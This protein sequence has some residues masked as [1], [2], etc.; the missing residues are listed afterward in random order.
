MSTAYYDRKTAVG[1]IIGTGTNGEDTNLRLFNFRKLYLNQFMKIKASYFENVER[2][3]T[4]SPIEVN[5]YKEVNFC[6]N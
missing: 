4:L 5:F 6:N 3:G 2:I 1:L